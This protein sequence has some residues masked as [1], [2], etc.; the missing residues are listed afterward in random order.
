ML[1]PNQ[2]FSWINA[3]HHKAEVPRQ[4]NNSKYKEREHLQGDTECKHFLTG[5]DS[6]P[7]TGS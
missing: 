7:D 4:Q 2:C 6:G 5:A 1:L 3:F